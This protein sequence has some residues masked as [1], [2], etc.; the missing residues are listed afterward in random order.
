LTG[1]SISVN[2]FVSVRTFIAHHNQETIP[3]LLGGPLV[4]KGEIIVCPVDGT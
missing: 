3:I 1:V 2:M 4:L